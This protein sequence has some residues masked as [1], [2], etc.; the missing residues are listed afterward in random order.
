MNDT[1]INKYFKD[2]TKGFAI[3]KTLFKAISFFLVYYKAGEVFLYILTE[4]VL[5]R[6][7][8]LSTNAKMHTDTPTSKI[9]LKKCSLMAMA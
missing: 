3:R 4:H 1:L 5:P 6:M 9:S 8:I 2:Y 7:L